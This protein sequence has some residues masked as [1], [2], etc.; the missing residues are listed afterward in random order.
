[1]LS[2]RNVEEWD[3]VGTSL[4]LKKTTTKIPNKTPCFNILSFG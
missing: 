2:I 4:K 3:L 1:M